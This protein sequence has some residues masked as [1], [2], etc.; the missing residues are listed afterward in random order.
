MIPKK[1]KKMPGYDHKLTPLRDK[2]PIDRVPDL[3]YGLVAERQMARIQYGSDSSLD[4]GQ[5]GIDRLPKKKFMRKGEIKHNPYIE[6][7][8]PFK[9]LIGTD[10]P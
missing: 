7:V 10:P 6:G 2:R 9:S 5:N 4:N 3:E 1:K 8:G